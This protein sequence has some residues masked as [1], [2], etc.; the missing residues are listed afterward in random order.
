MCLSSPAK[1]SGAGEEPNA[2]KQREAVGATNATSAAPPPP[3]PLL[4]SSS[5]AIA[6]RW[7]G[8]PPP[9]LAG[10]SRERGRNQRGQKIWSGAIALLHAI[11]TGR[12]RYV[13][14]KRSSGAVAA[15]TPFTAACLANSNAANFKIASPFAIK[16]L[17]HRP[18]I[19]EHACLHESECFW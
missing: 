17:R 3:R 6:L 1:Q 11:C 9:P 14:V 8:S 12:A 13:L 2:R 10:R 16:F 7:A 15:T 4:R 5:E 19:R 18:E